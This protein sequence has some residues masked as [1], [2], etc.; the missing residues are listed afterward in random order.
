MNNQN[1][2]VAERYLKWEIMFI[3][4]KAT[5]EILKEDGQ[6]LENPWIFKE[7]VKE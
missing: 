7:G 6:I 5:C 1:I 4:T 3:V 2:G